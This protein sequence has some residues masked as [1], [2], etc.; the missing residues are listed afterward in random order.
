MS[1]KRTP[2]LTCAS[3]HA[4]MYR[5]LHL[6]IRVEEYFFS[7]TNNTV[8]YNSHSTLRRLLHALKSGEYDV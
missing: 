6:S 4:N 7:L 8:S 2:F 5:F 3:F 1:V